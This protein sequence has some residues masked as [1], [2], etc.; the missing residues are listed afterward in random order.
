M[1]ST[2]QSLPTPTLGS[3]LRRGVNAYNLGV[4]LLAAIFISGVEYVL[5][6]AG[7]LPLLLSERPLVQALGVGSILFLVM[8]LLHIAAHSYFG[9]RFQRGVAAFSAG[10]TTQALRLLAIVERPGIDH[11]D[12]QGSIRRLVQDLR[13]QDRVTS[14]TP[15]DA[16]E[17]EPL[18]R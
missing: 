8:T 11:Y 15:P 18:S 12:I 13:R 7:F 14:S 4:A 5:S 3:E 6:R 16:P 1:S 9:W 2:L 10:N 17:R